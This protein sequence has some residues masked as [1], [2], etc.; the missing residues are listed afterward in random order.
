MPQRYSAQWI[1]R[2][3][4]YP[5]EFNANTYIFAQNKVVA[6]RINPVASVCFF[7]FFFLKL[8]LLV[9]YE[10]KTSQK[11]TT[12]KASHMFDAKNICESH[13]RHIRFQW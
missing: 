11:T 10:S 9:T 6:S 7:L 4:A 5:A 12:K 2:A 3:F 1:P 8:K 13:V